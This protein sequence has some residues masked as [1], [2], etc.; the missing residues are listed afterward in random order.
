MPNFCNLSQ[1]PYPFLKHLGLACRISEALV[2]YCLVGG[3]TLM[4][5]SSYCS[6]SCNGEVGDGLSLVRHIRAFPYD[7]VYRVFPVF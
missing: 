3:H 4:L 2:F 5:F 7:S 6:K 1:F